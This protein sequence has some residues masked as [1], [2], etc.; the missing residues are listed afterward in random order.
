MTV[1]PTDSGG[2]ERHAAARGCNECNEAL[3]DAR[4]VIRAARRLAMVAMTAVV[5]G[6]FHRTRDVLD[7]LRSVLGSYWDGKSAAVKG[8]PRKS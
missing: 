6:D 8:V 2:V 7:Q 5:N 3:D 1:A 4:E